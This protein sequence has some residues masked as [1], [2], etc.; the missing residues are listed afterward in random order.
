MLDPISFS[1]ISDKDTMYYHE[2]IKQPDCQQ[3]FQAMVKGLNESITKG[4]W[5]LIPI[6]K[7]PANTKILDSVWSM[8][9]KREIISRKIYKWKARLNVHG[10][11]QEK[12]MNYNNTYSPVV[13]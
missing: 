1:S 13:G 5:S 12:G 4:Y 6:S 7:V 11:Q 9:R 8:K 2:A 3:F 10:G